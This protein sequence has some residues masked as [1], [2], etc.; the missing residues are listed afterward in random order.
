M[1]HLRTFENFHNISDSAHRMREIIDQ[2][3][4]D[5]EISRSDYDEV[6]NIAGE[7]NHTDNHEKALLKELHDLVY[8]KEIKIKPNK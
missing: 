5:G 3:I 4:A 7:D 1:R 6:I 2:A 8:N